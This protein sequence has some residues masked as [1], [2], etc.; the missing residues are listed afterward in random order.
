M[1][2]EKSH[3]ILRISVGGLVRCSINIG[4]LA[5]LYI[6]ISIGIQRCRFY[7]NFAMP[8]QTEYMNL[9]FLLVSTMHVKTIIA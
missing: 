1:D 6:V 3:G 2:I 7:K 5:L 4:I 9:V 8:E